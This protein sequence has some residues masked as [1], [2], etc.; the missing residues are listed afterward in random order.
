MNEDGAGAPESTGDGETAPDRRH[1]AVGAARPLEGVLVVDLSRNLPGPL[2]G[3]ALGD[4]GARVIKI[5][6]PR[7]GDPS[8]SAP[9][10]RGDTGALAGLLLG[11]HESVAL[12]LRKE[13]ACEVLDT[14]LEQADVLV[15]SFRP[16]TLERF[17]LAPSTLRERHPRLVICSVSGYGQ[18]GPWAGRSGHDL[19]Y[20]AL[21]GT[22]APTADVP[23]VPVADMVGGFAAA[24]AVLAALLR[25]ERDGQGCWI[26][27]ALL[28]AAAYANLVHWAAEAGGAVP[29]GERGMLTGG[30]PGY[31]VYRTR[32][33]G[34]LALGAL[35]PRFWQRFCRAVGRRTW[36][37]RRTSGD[38]AFHD[39]VAALIAER[40]RAEWASLLQE[41]DIPGEPVLSAAEALAHPQND[42]RGL[43][44]RAD[45]GTFR[46][47]FPARFDGARPW[48]A[49]AVSA[50]GRDTE[51][52]LE[53]LGFADRFSGFAS[54]RGGVGRRR[55]L[56]RSVL[57]WL[58]RVV[59]KRR[60]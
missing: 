3:R 45:G 25:R 8:R 5:E 42:V 59:G 14:L 6:E 60:Q 43:V 53:E 22:L 33:G 34:A 7:L 15:E 54:R 35:E 28:D 16:G 27:A 20:Q 19:T 52:V 55:S 12:D 38:A 32:D 26:D 18:E 31:R 47:G 56:R 37:V 9:P 39:E 51:A 17:G 4:L 13:A 24:T 44:R 57:G 30:W 48:G 41:H 50:L 58:G 10:V 1:E 21:A 23:A 2:V 11:G 40:S 29:V 46:L 49:D 36:I